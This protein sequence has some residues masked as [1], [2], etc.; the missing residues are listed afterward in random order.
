MA[1]HPLI[2]SALA[3]AE[4]TQPYSALPIV[5]A[6]VQ[7]KKAYPAKP[8]PV[9]VGAVR[10]LTMAGPAGPMALRVY[11]P[12]AAAGQRPAP[13]LVFFHG[14]G[15]VMLDLDTHDDICRRLCAGTSCVVVSV[16]YRLA[17]EHRF[18]AGLDECVNAGVKGAFQDREVHTVT[19]IGWRGL[20][21]GALLSRVQG[22][23]D[24]FVTIEQHRVSTDYRRF[25]FGIIVASYS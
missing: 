24:V 16:D 1:L 9:P 22:Q 25:Q 23:F 11:A 19:E 13:M 21:D 15:F 18:P 12:P 8:A 14:S 3:A 20:E 2:Q 7:A 10:D 5:E 17:P 6:R 4:G